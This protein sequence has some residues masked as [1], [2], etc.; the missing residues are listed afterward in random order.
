[1]G[2]YRVELAAAPGTPSNP[3]RDVGLECSSIHP[4]LHPLISVGTEEIMLY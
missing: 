2:L 4:S 3:P 1:M